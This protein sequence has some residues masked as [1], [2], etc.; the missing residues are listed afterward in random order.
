MLYLFIL[1]ENKH[2]AEVTNLVINFIYHK[3]TTH[4][5]TPI[6]YSYISVC[7]QWGGEYI[8]NRKCIS[9]HELKQ[10]Y[11]SLFPFC[12]KSFAKK[13]QW[14]LRGVVK[15]NFG[16]WSNSRRVFN[17]IW[18]C[19]ICKTI[20]DIRNSNIFYKWPKNLYL[21][22]FYFFLVSL[23]FKYPFYNLNQNSMRIQVL[24]SNTS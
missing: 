21:F 12:W 14:V 9:Q 8:L 15:K 20:V 23:H 2:F 19:E 3:S 6:F 5:C 16:S 13:R 24:L 10:Y 11:E 7:M 18:L 22:V 4:S 1:F 17:C